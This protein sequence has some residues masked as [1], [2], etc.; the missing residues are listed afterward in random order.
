MEIQKIARMPG[1]A[2]PNENHYSK[3]KIEEK[4]FKDACLAA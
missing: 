4:F 3:Q 2:I 1:G